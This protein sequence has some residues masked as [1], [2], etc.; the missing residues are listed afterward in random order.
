MSITNEK[1]DKYEVITGSA[2]WTGKNLKDINMES[3]I[4]LK[5]A[6]GVCGKFNG[7]FD[8]FWT[9]SDGLVYTI[10]YEGKYEKHTGMKKWLDGEKWGY[11][12]W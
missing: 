7:F 1:T 5:D 11:V 2:N 9:N 8:K 12:S 3:N 10:K 6:K 4:S